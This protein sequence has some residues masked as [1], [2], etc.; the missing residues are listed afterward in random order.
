MTW[1][2]HTAEA[3]RLFT[4]PGARM[5]AEELGRMGAAA[6]DNEHGRIV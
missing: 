1:R 4:N 5:K 6:D 3:H 2:G